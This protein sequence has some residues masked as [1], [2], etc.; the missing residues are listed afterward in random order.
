M[1]IIGYSWGLKCFTRTV[2]TNLGTEII[3]GSD[4]KKGS[5]GQSMEC[6]ANENFCITISGSF[7]DE[8]NLCQFFITNRKYKITVYC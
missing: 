4:G 6:E 5:D 2:Y 8:A 7:N 3:V 1:T